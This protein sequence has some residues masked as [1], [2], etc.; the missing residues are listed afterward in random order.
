MRI[1]DAVTVQ[2][3]AAASCN[4][5]CTYCG[6]PKH[7]PA[8]SRK[9]RELIEEI[10]QVDPIIN[11]IKQLYNPEKVQNFS[12]WGSEPS[13]T[14]SYF[15]PF[16]ERAMKEFP[17]FNYLSFSSN[18][19][20]RT[21]D[22]T[23]FIKAF[24]QD[25]RITFSIQMSLDGP[26]WITDAN[27]RGGATET[28]IKNMVF[29]VEELNKGPLV[30]SVRC[31]FK[32][33]VS[34]EQIALLVQDNG[35]EEYYD[36]FSGVC[37]K[38]VKSNTMNN[39]HI[40][41][42]PEPTM[43]CPDS[44]TQQDGKNFTKLFLDTELLFKRKNYPFFQ[45]CDYYGHFKRF[46]T[47]HREFFTKHHQH[48]CAAAHASYGISDYIGPCHDTFYANEE[49]INEVYEKDSDR[50]NSNN[51]IENVRSGRHRQA[52]KAMTRK[53]DELTP[54]VMQK[55]LYNMKAW[56][57]FSRFK[58]SS[59]VAI[60]KTLAKAGQI[61]PCYIQDD[62][63]LMLCIYCTARHGCLV[64]DAYYTGSKDILPM[65]YYK[66]FGNGL[67]EMFVKRMVNEHD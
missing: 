29:F 8:I 45:N 59:G 25:R 17:N 15:G 9:H 55:Y 56:H 54:K 50:L 52:T 32:S 49:E 27:R 35:I 51:Q 44:Y 1:E 24:P 4:L 13:L 66:L 42:N 53:I 18:F 20:S 37:D 40:S 10:K 30:H 57:G 12:H 64:Q 38:L 58:L 3:F 65:G 60:I 19:L 34:K 31:H 11:R 63:A 6:I 16:Y 41:M 14:I 22:I 28:I 7:S 36:F 21:K 62:M 43:I 67:L 61:S 39:V 23:D 47:K 5:D 2:L 26:A 48:K 33:T 46:F